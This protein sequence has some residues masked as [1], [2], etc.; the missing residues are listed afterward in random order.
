MGCKCQEKKPESSQEPCK[1]TTEETFRQAYLR[2]SQKVVQWSGIAQDYKQRLEKLGESA[3]RTVLE[4]NDL[5]KKRESYLDQVKRFLEQEN[6]HLFQRMEKKLG[7]ISF[8]PKV[9]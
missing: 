9:G 3:K 7:P 1:D 5:L 4:L 6:P 2:Q 8:T